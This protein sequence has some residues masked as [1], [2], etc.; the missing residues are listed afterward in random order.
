MEFRDGFEFGLNF[1][2]KLEIFVPFVMDVVFRICSV[3][4]V[5]H[6]E[7]YHG[8]RIFDVTLHYMFVV[9]DWKLYA[10]FGREI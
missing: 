2:G 5:F 8:I 9:F 7:W 6:F 10:H 3:S 1:N 4:P